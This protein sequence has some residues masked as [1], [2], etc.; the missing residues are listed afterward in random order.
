MRQ[1]ILN[2]YRL[3]VLFIL[4]FIGVGIKAQD[5]TQTI[6]GRVLDQDSKFQAIGASVI[7]VGSNP[8]KGA[9][10]DSYG[11]YKIENVPVGRVSIEV[12]YIG[13]E[14]KTVPNVLVGSGKETIINVELVESFIN[15]EGVSIVAET[16]KKEALN[17][18]SQVSSKVISIEET[19]RYAG[20]ISDPSRMVASYA[21]VNSDAGGNNDIIVRGNSPKGILWRMEGVEI[22]NPNH[23]AEEGSTGGAISALN[24]VMLANSDFSTGA[25]APE[26]GNALSGIMDMKLRVGNNEKREYTFGLGVL[27]TDI[28]LE[29][30][31]KKG[32]NASYLANYR[33]SSLSL[34]DD[35]GIV[36]FGGVPKYQD[37]SF[38]LNFPTQKL[39]IISVFGLGGISSISESDIKTDS[40]TNVVNKSLDKFKANMGIVGIS[41]LVFLNDKT[42]LNTKVSISNNGSSYNY[43][44]SENGIA[45]D[46]KN[47]HLSKT[48][49]RVSSSY[50]RKFNSRNRLELGVI[51]TN[52]SYDFFSEYY[53]FNKNEWIK[54]LEEKGNLSYIQGYGSWKHRLSENLTL[55]GGAHYLQ[56][57]LN[58]SFSVEPRISAKWELAKKHTLTAGFGVHSKIESL[59]S[60]FAK[61][62]ESNGGYITPNKNL[63]LTKANH[64][65]LGY[66]YSIDKNTHAKIV[67]YY[68]KL[69]NVPISADTNSYYST[70]NSSD[71]YNNIALSNEGSGENYGVELTLERFFSKN[72]YYLFSGSVYNS[73][74]SLADGKKRNSKYN[75]NYTM[76][77]LIGKE[78][79]YG[80]T[81]N[82]VLNLSTKL[83]YVGANRY[84][85][86]DFESSMNNGY[87]VYYTDRPYGAK[88]ENVFVLNV[89]ASLQINK[90]RT[91]HI[92]KLELLNA[93]NNQAKLSQYYNS[94]QQEIGY[95]SQL[96]LIPNLIYQIQF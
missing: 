15:L 17:E 47:D 61:I 27:G 50:N 86:L 70:I 2:L 87:S 65:L 20:T 72:F 32:S 68:Q 31:F 43:S 80:T 34:L 40:I 92:V 33:Y 7:L 23:F 10:T 81:K 11:Y 79:T 83:S 71:W 82:K 44:E 35:T 3:K 6:K 51:Y 76:N 30:P 62:E 57:S 45:L 93:T 39:G 9:V 69:Y 74:Y 91:A 53:N 54:E 60:Y 29:G 1:F 96:E 85:P 73:T 13:Y 19:K 5:L 67:G 12:S 94:K 25:F 84:T 14:T 22:P 37:G 8:L 90:K 56:L 49:L 75:G 95:N 41:N 89:G 58:K 36:D 16:D 28:T 24:S 42:S 48:S 55:V 4:S 18:M 77:F 21:G 46:D 64:Y 26:Y 66:D 63:D 59:L 78:I 52:Q 38:K 88:G